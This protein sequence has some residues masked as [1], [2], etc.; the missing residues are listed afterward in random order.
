LQANLIGQTAEYPV[1]VATV[2]VEM[3]NTAAI[4]IM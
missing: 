3:M 4:L 2:D 1:E